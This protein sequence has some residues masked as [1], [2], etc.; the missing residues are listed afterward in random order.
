MQRAERRQN[1]ARLREIG[2]VATRHGFGL[3]F[4]KRRRAAPEPEADPTR[5]RGR[6]LRDMLD[7]LGPTFVK[8]GQLLSTR[9]DV[10]PPDVIKELRTLQ[11]AARPI[12]AER[13]RA[14]IE[15][16]LGMSIARVF[17]RFDDEPIASASI[18]QVHRARLPGGREVIVKVQR[19]DAE[20]T[21]RADIALLEQIA[22][23]AKERVRRLEFIDT[24]GLVDEFART[25]RQELDY[26][27]EARNAEATRRAFAGDETVVV[28]AVCWRQTTSRVLVLEWIDGPTLNHADLSA[29]SAED[30]RTLAARISDTWMKMVFVHGFFHADPHPANIVVQAPDR[31]GVIDFGMVGQLTARDRQA[32]VHVF[33]DVVEQNLDR[34]PRRLRDLGVRYPKEREEEFRDQLGVILQRHWGA[35]MGEIDGRELI[36][37]IF[38]AIYRLEV[39]IP[40]R[41]V[42]LDKAIATLAG[43]CLEISPDFNVFETARPHARRLMLQRFRPDVMLDRVQGDAGRYAEALLAFPFQLHDLMDELRDGEIKIAIQQEGFTEST[44]RALGA[45][46]RVVMGL[47]ASALFL[48]SAI[49]GGFVE[50]GPDVLGVALI[51]IPGLVMGGVV[52]GAVLLGIMRSGRW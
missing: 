32:A 20:E 43:V 12:P 41:W 45:T 50:S 16:E 19:P 6:R 36:R 24:V 30:R 26:R 44:E 42:L 8:F 28:P 15:T 47:L 25:V 46:N 49:I 7:E 48:G 21:L 23:L 39:K 34:L 3:I 38:Q 31:I 10:V 9:P 17:E 33:V 22:R 14:V 1:I 5:T 40:T 35:A 29:W 13:A 4:D 11:D 27:I 2:E 52:A 18:G 51:A 37:D